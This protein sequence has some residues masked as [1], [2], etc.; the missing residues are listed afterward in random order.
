[1][2]QK[3]EN[4]LNLAL[5]TP[6]EIRIRT[7]NLNVGYEAEKRTWEVIVKY[8]DSIGFLVD[9]GILVEEL[10]AGYAILTVPEEMVEFLSEVEQI[11]YVEK[12][13][14]YF[15]GAELPGENSCV[16]PV[17]LGGGGLSGEGVL[18]AVIDSGIAY[19]RNDFR[20]QDGN[21]RIVALWD[22]TVLAQ[23]EQRAP[24]GFET[25]V[26]FAEEQINEAL[27]IGGQ[28]GFQIVPSRDISGHGTAVAGI[29]AGSRV[30]LTGGVNSGGPQLARG[31]YQGI[32][33]KS[34]LLIVKLGNAS[35]S[36]L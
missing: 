30:M 13:K 34:D 12:P 10:I 7:G 29:L 35:E 4:L 20:K 18:V 1:M 15:F 25:G 24:E 23:G 6:E 19:E 22:Q 36:G 17:S 14:R 16:Y 5:E 26:E 8:H 3:F 33:Q 28:D 31:V 21:T 32:A 2:S 9:Y 27:R 11:E